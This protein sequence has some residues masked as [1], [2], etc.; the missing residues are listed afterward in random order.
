VFC[1][2]AAPLEQGGCGRFMFALKADHALVEY[3][4]I[5]KGFA[6]FFQRYNYFAANLL[7]ASAKTPGLAALACAYCPIASYSI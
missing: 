2:Q 5:T 1:Q 4:R 6:R 7:A 3:F